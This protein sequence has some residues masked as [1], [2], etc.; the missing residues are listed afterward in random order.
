MRC[1]Y[2]GEQN[3]NKAVRCSLCGRRLDRAREQKREKRILVYGVVLI[4]M[5]LAAGISAMYAVSQSLS[6]TVEDTTESKKVKIVSTPTPVPV[7][8]TTSE[9]QGGETE[10]AETAGSGAE[11]ASEAASGS[12]A[13]TASESGQT[14]TAASSAEPEPAEDTFQVRLLDQA[15]TDEILS[16]GYVKAGLSTASATSS[17]YQAG[18]DNSPYVLVDGMDYSSW[19]DGVDGPGIGE[20]IT[21]GFDREYRV[22][23]IVLRLGNWYSDGWNDY[24]IRNNRPKQMMFSIG[25]R[26]FTVEFPDE[27]KEYCIEFSEEIPASALQM[28]IVDVYAGTEFDDTCICEVDTYGY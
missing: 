22:R 19:Q 9:P 21:L 20:S 14:E 15:K 5:I 3:S 12:S 10:P 7:P 1:P 24:Y 8:E 6:N 13:E 2:C 25:G 28:T 16:M 4:L 11:T 26:E 17:L 18:I 23:F 27:M